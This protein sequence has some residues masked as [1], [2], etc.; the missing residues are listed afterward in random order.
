[1]SA[2][3]VLSSY[4]GNILDFPALTSIKP[5]AFKYLTAFK[6]EFLTIGNLTQKNIYKN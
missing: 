5:K 3:K 4:Q 2:S 1:V 6:N